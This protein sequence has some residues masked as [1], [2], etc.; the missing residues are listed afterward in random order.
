MFKD[1]LAPVNGEC[2]RVIVGSAANQSLTPGE[3]VGA[4]RLLVDTG[5]GLGLRVHDCRVHLLYL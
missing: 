2:S 3:G 5:D 4:G 1:H